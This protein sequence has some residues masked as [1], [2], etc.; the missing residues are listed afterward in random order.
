MLLHAW[1]LFVQIIFFTLINTKAWVFAVNRFSQFIGRGFTNRS[2]S[3]IYLSNNVVHCHFS[4]RKYAALNLWSVIK[5]HLKAHRS[6]CF[7]SGR[8]K[9]KFFTRK[10]WWLGTPWSS[11][12][13]QPKHWFVF[14]LEVPIKE[15]VYLARNV[16]WLCKGRNPK[17]V[18]RQFDVIDEE[19]KKNDELSSIELQRILL[20]CCNITVST[21]VISSQWNALLRSQW[22]ALLHSQKEHV[23]IWNALQLHGNFGVPLV[24]PQ[25]SISHS[26]C[27]LVTCSLLG[28]LLLSG[29]VVYKHV[30][31][32]S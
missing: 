9:V 5:T 25:H 19:M 17:L 8:R 22:N 2:K 21:R 24:F 11:I 29:T 27:V 7:C 26:I 4:L 23:F 18:I 15:V 28:T 12:L 20:A 6:S 31:M 13:R 14:C 32:E 16:P 1:P 3:R 10:V 30:L